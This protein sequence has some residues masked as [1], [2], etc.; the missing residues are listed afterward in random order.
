LP[1]GVCPRAH[2]DPAG[3]AP[4]AVPG[5]RRADH[6]RSRAA[7]QTGIGM[8]GLPELTLPEEPATRAGIHAILGLDDA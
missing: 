4:Q 8:A 5:L 6:H 1:E 7:P 2:R 3:T